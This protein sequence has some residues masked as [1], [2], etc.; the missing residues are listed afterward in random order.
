MARCRRKEEIL[1]KETNDYLAY[2]T[3]QLCGDCILRVEGWRLTEVDDGFVAVQIISNHQSRYHMKALTRF[4]NAWKVLRGNYRWSGFEL[5]SPE[6][7]KEFLDNLK[8]VC[9]VSFPEVKEKP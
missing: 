9:E 1:K 3:E 6:E 5:F 8:S 2:Y 7:A 4:K